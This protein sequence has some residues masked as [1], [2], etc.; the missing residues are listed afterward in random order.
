VVGRRLVDQRFED[1]KAGIADRCLGCGRRGGAGGEGKGQGEKGGEAGVHAGQVLG[2]KKGKS[3][4][5][6]DTYVDM[7]ALSKYIFALVNQLKRS[8][9]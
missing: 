2:A 1:F 7:I 9:S 6:R 4:P 5:H 3:L 8:L